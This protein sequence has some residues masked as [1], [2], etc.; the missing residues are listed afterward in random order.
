VLTA[1][2]IK[3]RYKNNFLGY[4]WSIANPLAFAFVFFVA[5]KVVMR[6]KMEDYSLFLISGLFP[7]QWFSNSVNTSPSIFLGNS[8]IIKK[9]SFRR[10]I[11]PLAMILQDMFHFI[12]SIPV[13]TVFLFLFGKSPSLSWLYGIPILLVL[14][15]L[16]TYGV[17]LVISS[18]NLFFRDMER[19]TSIFI[20]FLFYFTPIIYNESMIPPKFTPLIKLNPISPLMISWRNLFLT[21]TLEPM[22]LMLTAVYGSLA[23]AFGYLIYRRL[24]WRFAE[25]L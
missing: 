8:S 9:V 24:S 11:I 19:L 15:L 5:F 25:V 17:S 1:K 4:L 13:I 16:I 14:Q 21:G 3:V 7:W 20:T 6:I 22:Y 12:F 23:L 10:G 2:E 18:I